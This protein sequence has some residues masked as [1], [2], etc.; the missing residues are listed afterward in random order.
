MSVYA[1]GSARERVVIKETSKGWAMKRSRVP[2]ISWPALPWNIA[3][4]GDG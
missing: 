4:G 2:G 1:C 3:A